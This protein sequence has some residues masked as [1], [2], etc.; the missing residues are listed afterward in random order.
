MGARRPKKGS[1]SCYHYC[2]GNISLKR[3]STQRERER[4]RERERERE[5]QKTFGRSSWKGQDVERE[6]WRIREVSNEK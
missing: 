6:S 4:G 5:R 3:E 2:G 1:L